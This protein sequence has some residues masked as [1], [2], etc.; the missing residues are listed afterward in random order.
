MTT[1]RASRRASRTSPAPSRGALHHVA[2]AGLARQRLRRDLRRRRQARRS[3]SSTSTSQP[4]SCAPKA[5][6]SG[7]ANP[8]FLALHPN[9]RFVYAVSEVSEYEGQKT[10]AVAAFAVDA[11]TG[12]LTLLNRQAFGRRR[13]VLHHG[14]PSGAIRV[15][16]PT[17]AVVPWPCCPSGRDGKLGPAVSVVRHQGSGPDRAAGGPPRPFDR[18]RSRWP[19]C[20]RGRPRPRQGHGSTASARTGRSTAERHALRGPAARIGA[21]PRGLRQERR[22]CLRDQR[23]VVDRDHVRLRCRP[24]ATLTSLQTVSTL[25]AG[26][27]GKSYPAEIAVSPDGRVPLWIEPRPRLDRGRSRSTTRPASSGPRPHGHG[28]QLAASLRPR[29]HRRLS[30]GR[31]PAVQLGGG[32]PD[33]PRHRCAQPDRPPDHVAEPA[34]VIF[35]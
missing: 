4:A 15:S 32:L 6:T 17:T 1:G 14:R 34:C 30:A 11:K 7:L 23:A 19:Q 18:P 27:T 16:W 33:R 28:R 22:V 5:E 12:G 8:S 3:T 25:P 13:S 10:G 9:R 26:Y 31:E 2:A 35:R 24:R 21:A 20:A 29:P